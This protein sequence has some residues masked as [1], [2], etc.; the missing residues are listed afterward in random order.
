MDKPIE[1]KYS[2]IPKWGIVEEIR[3]KVESTLK[4]ESED[5]RLACKMTTSELLENAVKY[6]HATDNETCIEFSFYMNNEH[7]TIKVKNSIRTQTD[8]ED[9]ITH[10]DEINNSNNPKELYVKQLAALM[11]NDKPGKSQ[12]GLYRIAYEGGFTLKYKFADN[13]LTVVAQKAVQD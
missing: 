3:N 7:V 13:E 11:K 5:F 9:V 6:G 8:Y 12:L 10:I 4:Q 1:L 2:T